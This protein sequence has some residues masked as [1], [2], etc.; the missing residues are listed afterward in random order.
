[1]IQTTVAY[2]S[3]LL[4]KSEHYCILE[5]DSNNRIRLLIM[6][7]TPDLDTNV[8]FDVLLNQIEKV[9]GAVTMLTFTIAGKKYRVDLAAYKPLTVGSLFSY[10]ALI[11]NSG[12]NHW[13]EAFKSSGIRVTYLTYQRL[14]L[15]AAIFTPLLVIA[16][17]LPIFFLNR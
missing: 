13:I 6:D 10:Y 1:M 3:S 4:Q 16:I 15:I 11:K 2:S 7:T 8:V 14:I 12:I 9:G 5:W 17:A